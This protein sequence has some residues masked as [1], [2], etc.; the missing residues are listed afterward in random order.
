[1]LPSSAAS[2]SRGTAIV[3]E[4]GILKRD[5]RSAHTWKNLEFRGLTLRDF[6]TGLFSLPLALS[7][8]LSL[9]TRL[10]FAQVDSVRFEEA[11][12]AFPSTLGWDML[13]DHYGYLWIATYQQ[14]FKYDGYTYSR[15]YGG[16][17]LFPGGANIQ[18]ISGGR[19]EF[20]CVYALANTIFLYDIDRNNGKLVAVT[21]AAPER[22]RRL[23][24]VTED[25]SGRFWIGCENGEVLRFNPHDSEFV[26]ILGR[27]DTTDTLPPV[28]AIAEDS[29][30]N[31]WIGSDGGLLRI[32]SA[33]AASENP[34][35]TFDTLH[36]LPSAGILGLLAGRDGRL[37]IGM[38][39][40]GFGWIEDGDEEFHGILPLSIPTG[41]LRA[42]IWLAE[43]HNGDLWVGTQTNG[44]Y[45]WDS[46]GR[47]WQ[48]Y[49]A[50]R[51]ASGREYADVIHSMMVDQSGIL[52][53]LTNSRG[54]LRHTP[55]VRA[56]RSITSA[57]VHG[58][59]SAVR[60][61]W[62]ACWIGP[63]HSGSEGC[64]AGW[65]ASRPARRGSAASS[66]SRQILIV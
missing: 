17:S 31:I 24:C 47:R 14:C 48:K 30:G 45:R 6:R 66:M 13:Q 64:L 28:N 20:V 65:T 38:S 39:D 35:A 27:G 33:A 54:L 50:H 11:S 62:P 42:R 7:L 43:D 53:V 57:K 49:L 51:D 9:I 22:Y 41:P 12:P 21:R 61:F 26:T 55:P 25:F 8:T 59:D 60:M 2:I 32:R 19:H 10:S 5:Y 3:Y 44:L 4:D 16:T 36:G 37:W 58:L 23:N 46:D 40:G 34:P 63:A 18:G 29:S 1:M 15:L 52:W 56:F